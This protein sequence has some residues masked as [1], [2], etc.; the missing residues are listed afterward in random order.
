MHDGKSPPDTENTD[1]CVYS[2]EVPFS[3]SDIGLRNQYLTYTFAD[4][5]GYAD[6]RHREYYTGASK[7]DGVFINVLRLL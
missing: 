2:L 5:L 4:S 3:K 7:I 6:L 1:S